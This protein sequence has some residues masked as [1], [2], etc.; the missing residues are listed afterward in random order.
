MVIIDEDEFLELDAEVIKL[1]TKGKPIKHKFRKD[2]FYMKDMEF[3]NRKLTEDE[4]DMYFDG[5]FESD[6][7]DNFT[8]SQTE[9]DK[10]IEVIKF[11]EPRPSFFL[12]NLEIENSIRAAEVAEKKMKVADIKS[13]VQ[14]NERLKEFRKTVR[15]FLEYLDISEKQDNRWHNPI[16]CLSQSVFYNSP[17]N[18]RTRR[19]KKPEGLKTSFQIK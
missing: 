1:D 2:K 19:L 13:K 18:L 12:D 6:V 7:S 10:Q 14:R 9:R 15:E 16:A 8:Y 5:L 3:S 17:H 11:V 4:K